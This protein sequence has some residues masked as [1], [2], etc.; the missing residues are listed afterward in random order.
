MCIRDRLKA[1][2]TVVVLGDL[3]DEPQA[4]TTQILLGPPGSELGTAGFDRPDHG[5]QMRLWNLAPKLPEGRQFTRRF[6]GRGELIDHIL[7]SHILANAL[8]DVDTA[9]VTLPS[10]TENPAE[11]RD[12]PGSDHAPVVARFNLT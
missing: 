12:A 1:G 11:R 6:R 4:A 5:D 2:A 3:N 7:V 10:I 8:V 9:D